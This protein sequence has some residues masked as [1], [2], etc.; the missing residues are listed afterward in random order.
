MSDVNPSDG[1]PADG[2]REGGEVPSNPAPFPRF[3]VESSER[4]YRSPWVGLRRDMLKLP[5]GG[6]QEHH[7]IEISD[8]VCVLPIT[9]EGRILMIGQHRYVHGKTHWEVPAGRLDPGEDPEAGARRELAEETG[10]RAG[11]MERLPGFYPTNG[12]SAHW[13]HLFVARDC[14]LAGAQT[15]DAAERILVE[16]FTWD[17]AEALLRAGRIEDGFAALSLLY[18]LLM[19]R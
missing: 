7:V 9:S 17:E 4:I 19:V 15:L 8:A 13:A 12:I 1:H 5:E 2:D 18:G 14:E 6:S 3:E 16:T 11:N 10:Y